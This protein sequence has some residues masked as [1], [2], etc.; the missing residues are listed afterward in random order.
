[1]PDGPR[2][3]ETP[4][5]WYHQTSR[6]VTLDLAPVRASVTPNQIRAGGAAE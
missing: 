3:F 2:A 5:D 1:M 6:W 4:Q